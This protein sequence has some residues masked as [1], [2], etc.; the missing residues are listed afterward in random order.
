MILVIDFTV[1]EDGGN[2][3]LWEQGSWQLVERSFETPAER[4]MIII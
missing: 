2:V 4:N 1:L 3:L